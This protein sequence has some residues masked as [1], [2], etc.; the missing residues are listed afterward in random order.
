MTRTSAGRVPG[1]HSDASTTWWPHGADL[2][3]ELPD[4]LARLEPQRG[5]VHRLSYNID[6]W[7]AAARTFDHRGH[8]VRLDGYHYMRPH[9]VDVLG[10]DG[11]W[12]HLRV[13]PAD[14]DGESAE[15]RW[16]S[17][18]GAEPDSDQPER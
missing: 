10:V 5:P 18:G 15:Q 14:I 2:T 7:P 17:E 1:P 3:A 6:E 12:L 4:L 16:E 11:H 13:V 8:R 9:T